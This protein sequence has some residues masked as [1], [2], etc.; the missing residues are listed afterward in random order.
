[1]HASSAEILGADG[2][3][4]ALLPGF[5]ARAGQCELAARI[6]T[7]IADH[8]VF[9]AESGTGT[10]KTFAYLVP[11]LLSG[12]KVLVSTGTKNLQDQLFRRDLPIV[13]D[14]VKVPVT[15]ALLKGRANYLCRHRFEQLAA[16]GTAS[17]RIAT[18]LV[19][20]REWAGRTRSG[21]IGELDDIPEDADIWPLV[22][23]TPDNCLG[24]DCPEFEKC[25][26]NRARR[27]ALGADVLVVNHHLFFADLAL[28]EEGFGQLLPGV[29]VVVFDEAHQLPDIA[30][31]FFGIS[32]SGHQL[33][34]LCRD[35]IAEE[36]KEKSGIVEIRP[37]AAKLEK[38]VA[39]FRLAFGIE[40]RRDAW[41]RIAGSKPVQAALETLRATLADF[42]AV[43]DLAAP[44]G[45]GLA[46]CAR[47]ASE[48]L[49]RLLL[50]TGQDSDERV[51]WFET[52]ARGFS[53][54]STPLDIAVPFRQHV[55]PEKAWVFTSATLAVN[56]DFA[57]FQS[58]LGLDQAE[59][60]YWESPFDYAHRTLL[61]LPSGLPEPAAPDY[62][63]RVVRAAL[64]VLDASGGRAF[65]LFT[66]HRALKLAAELLQDRV[67]YPL[68]VQGTLPRAEL[69]E[70]FRALGN[71]V[72][73]GTS[74]FWEGVDVRGEALSCV[75]I[76]KLPFA[77]PDD[78]VLRARGA[79]MERSGRSP[80]MEHQLPEAVIALKQGVG[81]LIRDE[82]DRGVMVLC[83]PRLLSKGYGR[84]FLRSLPPMPQS[85][86]ISAVQSF[87]AGDGIV[88]EAATASRK[89]RR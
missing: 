23:S 33:V 49:D 8:A 12:K 75:I 7:A 16:E 68:L 2:P 74:S 67:P 88:S 42:G 81:R 11:A 62:T 17:R 5:R 26:V 54:S 29:E 87:F 61:Y 78:P 70:R 52:S 48:L 82:N 58:Q 57:H 28:K 18:D 10:G 65:L 46:G 30:T 40:P 86:E 36:L 71:A 25:H 39:D 24:G 59:T 6:E 9:V 77:T 60:G 14:A 34:G 63:E 37:A 45:Q 85:R 66:S 20:L 43:L 38:A 83:D 72:L 55:T 64:P 3:F 32:L 41:V 19:R 51:E 15:T 84:V 21:D 22:T 89:T 69:L 27:E 35:A 47:R 79:A 44:T 50:I 13:R 80:F 31:N 53:L 4:A 1:M 56:G 73:L 76:D